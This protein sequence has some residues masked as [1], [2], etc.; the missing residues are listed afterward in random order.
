MANT[1]ALIAQFNQLLEKTKHWD[2]DER[3]M[4]TSDLCTELSKDVKLDTT[5]ERRIC[6]AVLL[7]LD[8]SSNDVQSIA[9][10]CLGILLKK[11]QE[12]QV[13][14]ICDKLCSLIL[15]GKAELRD[16]Y[17]I[18]LKT[19]IADV[20]EAMGPSV[21]KRLTPRLFGGVAQD[22]TVEVKLE[23][24]DNL[25]DLLR[26]FGREVEA[27][28]EKIITCVTTQLASDKPVVRKRATACLGTVAT[29]VA[30]PLLNRLTAHLLAQ[31]KATQKPDIVRTYI[32]VSSSCSVLCC[33]S[34]IFAVLH[35]STL[36]TLQNALFEA[37]L[38]VPL[39]HPSFTP[40]Q[41]NAVR[42]VIV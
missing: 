1:N 3:Y 28:H 41:S 33:A 8:D 10:K 16:I 19:L 25:T 23:C 40:L 12:A 34:A 15:E 13:G 11:V 9:V 4:A 17:S 20:P 31:I 36:L 21:A 24:L 6:Q 7:Q 32:Q 38:R 22:A 2:K 42:V 29:I 26:R 14:E 35:S 39:E 18:G 37:L 5:F 30:D 27:E